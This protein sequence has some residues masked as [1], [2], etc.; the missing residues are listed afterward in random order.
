MILFLLDQEQEPNWS[1]KPAKTCL[2]FVHGYGGRALETWGDLKDLLLESPS[3]DQ[4]DIVFLGYESRSKQA[5]ASSALIYN[6]VNRIVDHTNDILELSGTD[7]R[8]DDFEYENVVLVGHSLG[9]VLVRDVL[10]N[11]HREGKSWANRSKI[12]LFAPAHSGAI[13]L[14]L[15]SRAGLLSSLLRPIEIVLFATSPVLRDMEIE[16]PYL[17][18][19]RERARDLGP[20]AAARFVV[21]ATGDSVVSSNQ[22]CADPMSVFYSNQDH[23]SCCKPIKTAFLNPLEDILAYYHG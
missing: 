18:G 15:V 21:H 20:L 13:A 5:S 2:I 8:S 12:M 6:A 4:C 11:L 10:I 14:D 16:S 7:I 22:F 3:I 9:G 17:T 1:V 19:L 23:I